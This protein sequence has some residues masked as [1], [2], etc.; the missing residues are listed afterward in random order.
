MGGAFHVPKRLAELIEGGRILIIAV[1]IAEQF[2][3]LLKRGGIK[4]TVLFQAVFCPLSKL[5]QIPAGF[6]NADYRNIKMSTFNHSLQS[7]KDLLV[8]Q[9]ARRAEEYQ[10]IRFTTHHLLLRRP[11]FFRLA[12]LRGRQTDSAWRTELY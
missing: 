2:G 3:K 1:H 7:R 5:V 11:L 6:G 10:C 9:I 8:R 12:F 4:P